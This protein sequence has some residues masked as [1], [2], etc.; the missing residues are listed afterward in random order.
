M[1]EHFFLYYEELDWCARIRRAGFEIYVEP[2][3]KIYHKESLATGKISSLKTYYITRNRILFMRRNHSGWRIAAF[4]L[5]LIFF[6]IPKNVIA[7]LLKRDFNEL[8]AFGKAI[9]WNILD[10]LSIE[11]GE[12]DP[13]PSPFKKPATAALV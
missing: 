13:I 3:A 10:I 8:H 9:W 2:N 6:T 12:L 5:F 1:W 11:N 4:T 7:Y